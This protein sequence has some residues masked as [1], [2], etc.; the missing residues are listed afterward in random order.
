MIQSTINDS[1]YYDL[2]EYYLESDPKGDS[3]VSTYT[4]NRNYLHKLLTN[5][6]IQAIIQ[7]VIPQVNQTTAYGVATSRGALHTVLMVLHKEIIT[8]ATRSTVGDLK[9][10]P[11]INWK[12]TSGP[13]PVDINTSGIPPRTTTQV[14][15]GTGPSASC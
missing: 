3:L 5:R 8:S 11:V 14:M 4:T 10:P 12:D 15:N 2:E 6:E 1:K 9:D 7:G 13:V